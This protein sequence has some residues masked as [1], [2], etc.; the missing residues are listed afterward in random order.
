MAAATV[1][2]T[3]TATVRGGDEIGKLLADFAG[4]R[5]LGAMSPAHAVAYHR[6]IRC[7]TLALHP[8]TAP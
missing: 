5:T 1:T 4:P 7:Y 6:N 3:A 8:S 2:V